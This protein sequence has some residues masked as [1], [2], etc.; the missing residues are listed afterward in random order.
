MERLEFLF[1]KQRQQKLSMPELKEMTL[2]AIEE[3]E[4]A[5]FNGGQTADAEAREAHARWKDI[6]SDL[7]ALE[8][9]CE[10]LGVEW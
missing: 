4:Q 1:N 3:L 10:S 2:L 5:F 8:R 6:L 9:H 7:T